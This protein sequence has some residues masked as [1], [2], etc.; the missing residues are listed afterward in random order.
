MKV[1]LL[2]LKQRIK[3]AIF[4]ALTLLLI[5]FSVPYPLTDIRVFRL[6][7][8]VFLL[9]SIFRLYDDLKNYQTDAGK[10]NRIYTQKQSRKLLTNQLIAF[11]FLYLV[12]LSFV[13]PVL[14][15]L[16]VLFLV[17][18][19]VIYRLTF[20]IGTYKHFLPLLKYPV[21]V[22]L[23]YLLTASQFSQLHAACLMLALFC[24]FLVFEMLDDVTFPVPS[25]LLPVISNIALAALVIG[26]Y[27]ISLWWCY[28]LIFTVGNLLIRLKNKY[29]PYLFL[30]LLLAAKLALEW[31]VA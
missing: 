11:T 20:H 13:F 14:T 5:L 30:V 26:F 4:G 7:L 28:L 2:Y 8:P 15:V 21:I 12:A 29:V 18:N 3:P 27:Q 1:L 16:L 9:L 6:I 25:K 19:D 31:M 17:L 24:G 10:P 22:A 23:L